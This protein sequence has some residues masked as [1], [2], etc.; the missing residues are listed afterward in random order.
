MARRLNAMRGA[1]D[2]KA[3]LPEPLH[4]YHSE[5]G[6]TGLMFLDSHITDCPAR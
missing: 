4:I 3:C 1:T 5:I 6:V 2:V